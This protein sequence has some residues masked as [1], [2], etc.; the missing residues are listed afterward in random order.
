MGLCGQ[1]SLVALRCQHS[2]SFA[3]APQ[4]TGAIIIADTV[5]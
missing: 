3:F 4:A 2:S 5:Y 1:F